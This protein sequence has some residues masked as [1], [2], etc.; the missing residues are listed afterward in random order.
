MMEYI[1]ME[2]KIFSSMLDAKE[3]VGG[4]YPCLHSIKGN[5]N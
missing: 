2:E 3:G 5:I 1:Q 4:F